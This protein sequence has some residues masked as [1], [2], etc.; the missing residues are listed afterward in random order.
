GL[1][2]KQNYILYRDH[3]GRSM[4]C[5]SCQRRL[6]NPRPGRSNDSPEQEKTHFVALLIASVS[7]QLIRWAR[8]APGIF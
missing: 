2:R 1:E 7:S 6:P 3:V 8:D 5:S 4:T